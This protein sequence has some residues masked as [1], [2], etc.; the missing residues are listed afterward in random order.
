M[1]H[2]FELVSFWDG[3]LKFIYR[4]PSSA[5]AAEKITVLIICA[6]VRMDS[7]FGCSGE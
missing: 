4:S 7:L 3:F 6:K 2:F 5:S 1:S